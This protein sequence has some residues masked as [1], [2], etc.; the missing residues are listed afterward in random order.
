MK[1]AATSSEC[2]RT[3]E[4]PDGQVSAVYVHLCV[5]ACVYIH[6]HTCKLSPPLSL[7][8]PTKCQ[9]DAD[10]PTTC[11]MDADLHIYIYIYIY[12]YIYIYI[13]IY[14]YISGANLHPCRDHVDLPDGGRRCV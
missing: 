3:Y 2:E 12:V 13:Y 14:V 5:C 7:S 4:M 10:L 11:P 6:I 8:A 9:M 1:K